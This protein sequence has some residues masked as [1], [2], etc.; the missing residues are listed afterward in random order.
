MTTRRTVL[1]AL[2]ASILP[3]PSWSAVGDPAYLAAAKEPDG[4][5]SFYGLSSTGADLFRV[6]LPARAHAGAGHPTRPE[7]VLFARRPGTY[8]LVID[9]LSGAARHELTPPAGRQLNGHGIYAEDGDLLLTSEQESDTS[10]GWLGIWSTRNGYHRI[11]EIP[12]QGIGPHDVKLLPDNATL[13]VANGGIATDPTDRRKLNTATMRPNLTYMDLDGIHEQFELA[14]ELRM[15]SIRHL[16]VGPKGE[17]GF[18]MQ[19]QGETDMATPLIGIRSDGRTVLGSAPQADVLAMKGYAG[20]IAFDDKGEKVAITSPRGGR[21]QIYDKNGELL[22]TKERV[23][24]C[25]LATGQ[26]GFIASDGGG[27][28]LAFRKKG[29]EILGRRNRAWDNHIV[30]LEK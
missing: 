12:T 21:M 24:I 8:A 29:V 20:S 27:G 4:S 13:V 7:A 16:A 11:G 10:Q 18:A 9:C 25:G 3:K 5:F 23:D 6:P 30:K 1:T 15:N 17:V 26:A 19:W 28:L 22:D 2:A 14:P